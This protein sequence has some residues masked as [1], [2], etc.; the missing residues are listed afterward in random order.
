MAPLILGI[1]LNTCGVEAVDAEVNAQF[2]AGIAVVD[3]TPAADVPLSGPIGGSGKASVIHDRLYAR[4]L[5]IDDGNDRVVFCVCDLT[6]IADEIHERVRTVVHERTKLPPSH[7]LVSATHTHRSPRAMALDLGPAHERYREKL[8]VRIAEAVSKAVKNLE[9]ATIAWGAINKPEHSKNRRWLMKPGSLGPN[10]FGERTDQVKM[11]GGTGRV[12]A[13]GPVDP[14]LSVVSFQR[15][16]G[17]QLA[18]FANYSIHYGKGGSGVSADY[19]GY[20]VREVEE[21]LGAEDKPCMAVMSNGTSGDINSGG[22]PAH[23]GKSLAAAAIQVV[24]KLKHRKRAA[25]K[26]QESVLQ[27]EVRRPDAARLAWA[28]DV[29]AGT[30]KK[31]AHKWKRKYAQ[32]ALWLSKFPPKIPVR[33]R[34][35]RIGDLAIASAPC[36]VFAETGLAIK[37]QSPFEDTFTVSLAN[38]YRG[39]LPPPEQHA[40]G[41]YT[42]WPAVSSCLAVDAEPKVRAEVL[43]LLETL[44]GETE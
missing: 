28:K 30:W 20:F 32:S 37:E 18:L 21:K 22:N 12:R 10:P 39:Y 36:E 40:L 23:L 41:G 35:I 3:I 19:F 13:V 17:S 11:H 6:V 42:T 14:E 27:L 5:A 26:V 8:A 1:V 2:R 16:D 34:A 15:P 4:A 44:D 38:G 43:R 31:P 29:L 9:P 33:L 25:L 7:L 24:R